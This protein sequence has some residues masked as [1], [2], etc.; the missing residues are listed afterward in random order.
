MDAAAPDDAQEAWLHCCLTCLQ[1]F[2]P[3]TTLRLLTCV[4]LDNRLPAHQS[5]E[6]GLASDSDPEWSARLDQLKA[7]HRTH[8]DCSVGCRDGDDR[9]L[10]RWAAPNRCCDHYISC[11]TLQQ[12]RARGL[13]SRSLRP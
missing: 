1:A 13:L 7:Y 3:S 6:H 2:K 4:C 11:G 9:E 10:A 12:L 5:W 8:G